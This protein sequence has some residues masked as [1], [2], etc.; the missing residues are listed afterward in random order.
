MRAVFSYGLALL[1]T[2]VAGAWL[3]TG[4]FVQGGKGPGNGEEPVLALF[5]GKDGPVQTALADKGVL[6][7]HHAEAEV[8]PHLTIAQRQETSI[9]EGAA[10][11]S[12]RVK[13]YTA[14]AMSIDVPL[15]GTTRARATVTASAE[16]TGIVNSVEVAKGDAVA[17]GDLLCTIDPGTRQAAV[18][19][20]RAALAQAQAGLATAQADYDTNAQLRAQG[21]A[22]ANTARPFEVQL[23][24]AKAQ[25]TA[26]QSQVDNALAELERTRIFAKSSGIVQDPVTSV[27]SMLAAGQP[28]ATIVQLDPL[29]FVGNVPEARIGLARL[30]LDASITLISGE[31]ATGKVT[32][33]AS[34][35]DPA[36]R[37]FP[38]EISIPNSDRALRAGVTATA[39]VSLGS[40]PAQLLPQS[41]LTLDDDGTMGV[42]AVDKDGKVVFY[43]I[44]IVNDTREGMW[45]T[46]LPLSVDIITVG[47]DFVQAG[48]QVAASQAEE[49]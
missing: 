33:I 43:P 20:A 34:V 27:G 17:V 49:G 24:G 39:I 2:L 31:A 12:V 35:A 10:L 5:E 6:V 11:R 7:E 13:T 28:C 47:Q 38:V 3:A 30:G 23:E 19:Q 8:D 40:A 9:G 29:I 22:A 37:S 44:T 45:V 26:A 14:K 21:I 25:L 4:T 1:I 36:T 41:V 18:D 42:R 15:R 16:T 32:Y 46:G 48:Q